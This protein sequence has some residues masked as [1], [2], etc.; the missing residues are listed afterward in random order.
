M[1]ERIE[2]IHVLDAE[3]DPTDTLYDVHV[4]NVSDGIQI[5]MGGPGGSAVITERE[6]YLTR[7]FINP[8][9]DDEMIVIEIHDE[10][11]EN[12]DRHVQVMNAGGKVLF[13]SETDNRY[14]K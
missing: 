1:S 12:G 6:Q 13:D 10:T 4:H 7:I 11:E 2:Q 8:D 14:A 3:K 9:G 5:V